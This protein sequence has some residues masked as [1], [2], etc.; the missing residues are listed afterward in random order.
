MVKITIKNIF[1]FKKLFF[2][3]SIFFLLF[4]LPKFV[5]A[6]TVIDKDLDIKSDTVWTKEG[7]PYLISDGVSIE[8][9]VTLKIEAGTSVQ[10]QGDGW[11][12]LYGGNLDIKGSTEDIVKIDATL[13]KNWA[14]DNF[15]GKIMI[16]NADL[17]DLYFVYVTKQG[18]LDIKSSDIS[19]A[20]SIK[21]SNNSFLS[22]DGG[23]LSTESDSTIDGLDS[24]KI[25]LSNTEISSLGSCETISMNG[26]SDLHMDNV[27]MDFSVGSESLGIY[28]STATILNSQF[29]GGLKNGIDAYYEGSSLDISNSNI[30]NFKG[31]AIESYFGD[32]LIKESDFVSNGKA[33]TFIPTETG[34]FKAFK[35][36]I[37]GNI[38]GVKIS[39][40]WVFIPDNFDITNNYWGDFSGPYD[41]GLDGN[42][43]PVY[44]GNPDGLGDEISSDID[45]F[46]LY[47]PWLSDPAT[48]IK[49]NP[50]IIIPGI[51]SSY[52]NKEDGTEVWPNIIKASL[53]FGDKFLDDLLLDK[54][55]VKSISNIISKDIIRDQYGTDFFK[56]L[57]I[58][59]K[60]QY[61]EGDDLFVFPYDW[62]FDVGSTAEEKLSV[63]IE[64]ILQK[65][66]SEKVDIIAHSMGG[67]VTKSYIKT[68]SGNKIGKFIDIATPH[69]GAPSAFKILSF[70]DDIFN[71]FGI[72]IYNVNE[73]KKI[74]QNFPSIYE[75]LPSEKYFDP[76]NSDYKYY[77][78][79]LGDTDKNGVKGK[80]NF[81]ETTDFLKNSGRNSILL[82]QA[83]AYHEGILNIDP[84]ASGVDTVNI[85]GCGTP[86][87]GKIFTLDKKDTKN[88]YALAYINGD[89]TVPL[90]S[91]EGMNAE[92]TYYVSGGVEHGTMP[93]SSNVKDIVSSILFGKEITTGTNIATTT[94]NC[95]LPN[96]KYISI[97]SPVKIDIYDE[98]GNHSG[99]NEDGDI[100][101]NIAG[102]IY[103]T[104]EDNK[105]VF[106]PDGEKYK[107]NLQATGAGS[108]SVDIKTSKDGVDSFDY[109]NN[110]PIESVDLSGSIDLASSTP[111]LV[112][113]K[114]AKSTDKKLLPNI[115]SDVDLNEKEKDLSIQETSTSTKNLIQNLVTH[116]SSGNNINLLVTSSSTIN[117]INEVFSQEVNEKNIRIF[118]TA[119][120]TKNEILVISKPI[121]I[122]STSTL[123]E[124]DSSNL[125][126]VLSG[127]NSFKEWNLLKSL[128]DFKNL[129]WNFFMK[130]FYFIK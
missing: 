85:V 115:S 60:E 119:Q 47:S 82:D 96:G 81:F 99:P 101:Q 53:P 58:K 94:E 23:S 84:E 104:I 56:G 114:D 26:E 27:R 2:I 89:G 17:S 74:S 122:S 88:E 83:K 72:G 41:Q 121:I 50:V 35:N 105:F 46:S 100:E 128:R 116:H 55:G 29:E 1:L 103:D 92:I 57:I 13:G 125:A 93:S 38:I 111:V 113:K 90:R 79:D 5:W 40:S 44:K 109:F 42:H 11:L 76:I 110:I 65:T 8:R 80:L 64:D 33:F 62:R 86:T 15:G 75:L 73:V 97:H 59:L 18:Y 54:V 34:S 66:G 12:D 52:L 112:I 51:L 123:K 9:G 36:N 63:F 68:F 20:Y 30:S 117:P 107:I 32:I 24:S 69:L 129:V 127:V 48:H 77:F 108:F 126:G 22:V 124:V 6:D 118:D 16:S 21:I 98:R 28:S 49:H 10:F 39:S 43:K 67:L 25:Y 19:S 120:N 71:K 4:S 3:V 14:V 45:I 95:K 61:S 78:D 70:G 37:I 106:I 7:G 91:A 102:V 87:I 31:S 130:I